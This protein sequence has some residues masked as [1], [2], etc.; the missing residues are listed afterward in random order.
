[1]TLKTEDF[2]TFAAE[3]RALGESDDKRAAALGLTGPHRGKRAERLRQR[4][5]MPCAPLLHPR[6]L[7]ALLADIE[8]RDQAA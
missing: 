3:L 7:R 1:M 4:L 5:P 6:L 2:P 8:A